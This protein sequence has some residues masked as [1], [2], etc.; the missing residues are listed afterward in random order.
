MI[1]ELAK[2]LSAFDEFVGFVIVELQ[3]M[4]G[5]FEAGAQIVKEHS[6]MVLLRAS[7]SDAELVVKMIRPR[8]EITAALGSRI[9][10]S[11]KIWRIF[12]AAEV[13]D[14]VAAVG[15]KNPIHKLNPP[16]VPAFLLLNTLCKEFAPNFIKLKFKNFITA[17]ESLSLLVDNNKLLIKGAGV[18]KILGEL[19]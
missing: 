16:I 17:G 11:E 1:R 6:A 9:Q 7:S 13:L 12:T 8:K 18:T 15:D 10:S 4:R 2:K 14:F 5:T 19:S 3:F